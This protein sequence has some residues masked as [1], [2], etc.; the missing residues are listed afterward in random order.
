VRGRALLL[1]GGDPRNEHVENLR[2]TLK[3]SAL[4][5]P[6]TREDA[7]DVDSF[8][9]WIA[10]VDVAAVVLL[11]RWSRHAYG[12]VTRLCDRYDKPLVRIEAGYNV[13]QISRGLVEQASERLG[14]S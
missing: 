2:K 6:Q 11:I 3:L 5:W 9:P 1:L 14:G 12:D 8:E 10:R 7:P 13:V 4:H